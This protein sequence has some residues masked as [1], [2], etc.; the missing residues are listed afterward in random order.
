MTTPVEQLLMRDG[1]L[2]P[3]PARAHHQF[4]QKI[5]TEVE[6][7]TPV[8][9][10]QGPMPEDLAERLVIVATT[11]PGAIRMVR[12][13]GEVVIQ[14][15]TWK[16]NAFLKLQGQTKIIALDSKLLLETKGELTYEGID[17]LDGEGDTMQLFRDPNTDIIQNDF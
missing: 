7:E 1:S 15:A 14:S 17:C 13:D 6:I 8:D 5:L 2:L 3:K 4:L 11:R 9:V 10:P 16:T 12:V